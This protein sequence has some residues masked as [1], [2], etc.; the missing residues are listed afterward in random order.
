MKGVVEKG[1]LTYAGTPLLLGFE[2][3]SHVS[4]HTNVIFFVPIH[5]YLGDFLISAIGFEQPSVDF[6]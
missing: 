6:S 5:F 4:S 1:C 2:C 3:S